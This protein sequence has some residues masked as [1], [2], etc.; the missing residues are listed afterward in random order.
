MDNRPLSPHLQVYRLPL[1]AMLSITHRVTGVF[2]SAAAVLLPVY[3]AI[4]AFWPE[5]YECLQGLLAAWYGQVFLFGLS[6]SLIYHLLN[7]IRHLFWD[8]GLNLEVASAERSGYWVIILTLVLTA[9][10]W[11]MSCVYV[12]GGAQ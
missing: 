5:Y 6:A 4:V 8:V 7:G 2:L 10:I 9:A 11:G 12:Y 1:L 3:L